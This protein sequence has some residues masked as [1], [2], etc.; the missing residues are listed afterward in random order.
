MRSTL[1]LSTAIL[2]LLS[3]SVHGGN[4]DDFKGIGQCADGALLSLVKSGPTKGR[5]FDLYKNATFRTQYLTLIPDKERWSAT[6]T[7]P[8]KENRSY[9]S[10]GSKPIVVF[11]SCE[12]HNCEASEL[13]GILEESTGEIG[14]AILESGKIRQYGKLTRSGISAIACAKTLD[15]AAAKRSEQSLKDS[16]K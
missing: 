14:I 16:K 7:G 5:A 12:T 3:A 6:L 4:P 15:A 1:C 13:Y 2:T 11:H 8:S 9:V 10:Q